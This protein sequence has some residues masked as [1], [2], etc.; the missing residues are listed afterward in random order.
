MFNGRLT[1]SHVTLFKLRENDVFI[2]NLWQ[3]YYEKFTC[4]T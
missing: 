1:L 2:T 3:I 4:F